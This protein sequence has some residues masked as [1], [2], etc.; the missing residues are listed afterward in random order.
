MLVQVHDDLL[1]CGFMRGPLTF[2]FGLMEFSTNQGEKCKRNL[3]SLIVF[4][5]ICVMLLQLFQSF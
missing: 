4:G 3:Y 5:L 1:E 2:V